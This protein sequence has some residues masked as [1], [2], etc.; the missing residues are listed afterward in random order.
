MRF[1][2]AAETPVSLGGHVF[3]KARAYGAFLRPPMEFPKHNI[4]EEVRAELLPV[5]TA[6]D[7][8][9]QADGYPG[10][11]MNY[12]APSLVGKRFGG[13]QLYGFF[14]D[15]PT[16]VMNPAGWLRVLRDIESRHASGLQAEPLIGA[17]ATYRPDER[18]SVRLRVH[19]H[20]A[21]AAAF[22]VHF[23]HRKP[24]GAEWLPLQTFRRVADGGGV[25]GT[26]RRAISPP[27]RPKDSM[28]SAP[29]YGKTPRG[30]IYPPW[31]ASPEPLTP[32]KQDLWRY[33][34]DSRPKIPCNSRG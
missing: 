17:Y 12:Y 31:R 22:E 28:A 5:L 33:R 19:N 25:I 3:A 1:R 15:T 14:F 21:A 32:T 34:T 4:D 18:A 9:G 30:P 10:F 23:L 2:M 16:E 6:C 29:R 24:G 26:R 27:G 7:R 13:R 8:F 11:L 20:R